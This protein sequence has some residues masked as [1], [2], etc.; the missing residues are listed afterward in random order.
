MPN[1]QNG[2]IYCIRSHQTDKVYVGSTTVSLS[3]RMSNHRADYKLKKKGGKIRNK[4]SFE[5]LELGDAYIELVENFPCNSKEELEKREGFYIRKE[6]CV[7]KQIAGGCNTEEKNQNRKN[8]L[9]KY[10]KNNPKKIRESYMKCVS[11]KII[12]SCGSQMN[13]SSLWRHKKSPTHRDRILSTNF[14]L[15]HIDVD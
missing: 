14:I 4:T 3:R 12:C 6:N 2:K 13:L 7:N 11:K 9:K 5:L 1:Y 8:T 15:H 10:R